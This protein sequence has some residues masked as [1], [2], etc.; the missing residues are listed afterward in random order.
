MCLIIVLH[1]W[2]HLALSTGAI[3]KPNKALRTHLCRR[4]TRHYSQQ[5]NALCG[6]NR[7]SRM[8]SLVRGD[9]NNQQTTAVII[10]YPA[11]F[12]NV[13][14][15]HIAPSDKVLNQCH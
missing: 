8:T 13:R 15:I 10:N 1:N 11:T 12:K 9:A 2:F 14:D 4:P 7:G 5:M 3:D 6:E